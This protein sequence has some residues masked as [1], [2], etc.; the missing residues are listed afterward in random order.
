MES[1]KTQNK[2]WQ[3]IHPDFTPDLQEEWESRGFGYEEVDTWI[4]KVSLMPDDADFVYYLKRQEYTTEWC[5]KF[6]D[7]KKLKE[8]YNQLKK[9]WEEKSSFDRQEVDKWTGIG[10][11]VDN[12]FFFT[13][14]WKGKEN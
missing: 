12:D 1:N 8:G 2:N 6:Q 3:D 9:A 5:E 11:E 14:L 7:I 4:K 10:L 13:S